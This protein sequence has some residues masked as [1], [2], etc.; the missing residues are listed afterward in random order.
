MVTVKQLIDY[1]QDLDSTYA[2]IINAQP[3]AWPGAAGVRVVDPEIATAA[4]EVGLYTL[5]LLV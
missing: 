2:V 3:G 5:D 4:P 1:L